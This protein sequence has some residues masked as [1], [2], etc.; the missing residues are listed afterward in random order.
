MAGPRAEGS[1]PEIESGGADGVGMI[2]TGVVGLF[3]VHASEETAGPHQSPRAGFSWRSFVRRIRIARLLINRGPDGE[4]AHRGDE[5]FSA[6]N[7]GWQRP[8]DHAGSRYGSQ[9]FT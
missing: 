9:V 1:E 7:A 3:S 4:A 6:S 8:T 2:A 5:S